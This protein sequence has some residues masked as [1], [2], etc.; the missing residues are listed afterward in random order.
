MAEVLGILKHPHPTVEAVRA[1]RETGFEELEVFSPV[2]SH[3]IE[4]ALD[5]GPSR[6]RLWT[7]IGGLTGVTAGYAFTIW[8]AYSW[9]LVVGG[10][11]FASIP[12]Y[13]VIAF[14]LTIL[15]GGV[16]TVLGL[17]AH[18]M[19]QTARRGPTF[20]RPTFSEDEFGCL[21][22]CHT[23][24]IARVQEILTRAGCTEVRVV[25]A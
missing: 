4:G 17:I 11:P 18:G 14:E 15:F 20:Y 5:R 25:Q 13:T 7:L 21:V 23:D 3:E 22:R 16:L 12:A 10:K 6:V 1:L 24:Q 2:P 19:L 8:T 9:P